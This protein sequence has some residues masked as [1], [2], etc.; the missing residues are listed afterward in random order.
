MGLSRSAR[1]QRLGG[2][3]VERVRSR[4]LEDRGDP[5]NDVVR[6]VH[7]G[8]PGQAELG[9]ELLNR[10]A[11]RARREAERLVLLALSD[12]GQ[13]T[14][15]ARHT[16]VLSLPVREV[17]AK[18]DPVDLAEVAHG[19]TLRELLPDGRSASVLSLELHVRQVG[20]GEHAIGCAQTLKEYFLL[21]PVALDDGGREVSH[22]L[23]R[24]RVSVGVK[25]LA[26][27][28]APTAFEMR[29]P[30]LRVPTAAGSSAYP[31]MTL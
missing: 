31:K 6:V 18:A 8:F 5:R 4:V 9:T 1:V 28:Q 10:E 12:L 13:S 3:G 2:V 21:D 23:E 26:H 16:L 19:R 7:E 20:E 17:V 30:I 27:C 14:G 29:T 24:N 11:E 25:V 22:L 15:S